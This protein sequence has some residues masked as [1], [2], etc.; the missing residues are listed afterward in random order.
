M[1]AT[2]RWLLV[3]SVVVAL[4]RLTSAQEAVIAGTVIDSTGGVLPGVT[5]TVVHEAS[6]NTFNGETDTRGNF[7]MPVR[8]GTYRLT[9]ELEGFTTVTRSLEVLVG[10][11]V[12]VNL[13]MA[14]STVTQSVTVTAEAPL[15][16]PTQSKVS[17]N[18]DSRQLSELPVN[19]RSWLDLTMLTP[20][21]RTN[22]VTNLPVQTDG[23]YVNGTFQINLDGQQVTQQATSQPGFLQP[24]FSRDAIAEFEYIANRFDATQGKSSGVIINAV[25][26]SGTNTP[27]VTFSGYFRSD[28]FNAADFIQKRVLP[29]SDQQW[30]GTFG[31]PIRKDKVHFFV[32]YE[33]EREPRTITFS[34]P[35]SRFNID[36]ADT[37]QEHKGGGRL[38]VQFSSR[39][40]LQVRGTGWANHQPHDSTST[41]GAS[42]H[43]STTVTADNYDAELFAVLTQVPS[44]Q[45][46]K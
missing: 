12:S 45:T 28:R 37:R 25:T 34:S 17:G 10:Q 32:H 19:G 41:G 2:F 44:H 5:V 46:V 9:A 15:I 4:P 40:S 3:A 11:Q 43:P 30:S 23:S 20:G 24:S 18:I 39:T 26:K 27:A 14:L 33:Y 36:F 1:T 21:H 8:I 29:Y 42:R 16:N 35:Y 6:G 7:R 13:Q 22:A 31:G 38:D